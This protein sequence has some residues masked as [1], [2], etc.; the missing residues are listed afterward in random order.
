MTV[1]KNIG[2]VST[3]PNWKSINWAKVQEEVMKLQVRIA[4]ATK[5]RRWNKVKALQWLLTHSFSAKC[6]AVKRVTTNRGKKTPGVDGVILKK[7]VEKY[8]MVRSMSRR[9]YQPQ[10]LRRI[11]IPKSGGGNKKR[12]LGIPTMLDRAQQALHA[13]ALSPVAETTADQNSYGFRPERSTADAIQRIHATTSRKYDPQ[14]V[15]EGDIKGCFDNISHDW[16]LRNVVMDRVVLQKWLKAGFLE[17][18]TLFPTDK[19]T[20]QGGIISPCLANIVLDG[21]EKALGQIF[22]RQRDADGRRSRHMR[23]LTKLNGVR[24]CRYADDFVI[25]GSSRELLENEVKP[26]IEVFLKERGLELSDEKTKITHTTEGYDFLGQ[27]VRRHILRSGGSVLLIRPSKKNIHAFLTTIRTTIKKM[28]TSKQEDL[29]QKLNPM[30]R[31]WGNYHRHVAS[32]DVYNKVDHEIWTALW[33][34]AKRRH[35]NKGLKWI[36]RRY[37]RTIKGV[38]WVF[39]CKMLD[40]TGNQQLLTLA[41]TSAIRIIRHAHIKLSANPFDPEWDAYFEQRQSI[42]M[43]HSYEGRGTLISLWRKQEG[44]CPQCGEQLPASGQTGIIQYKKSRSK[45]GDPTLSNLILLH[46]KCHAEGHKMSS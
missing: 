19:G 23:R 42:K 28:A 12:P 17:K 36:N 5:Q 11:Y 18:A 16:L 29:I 30:I 34:W 37:F 27:H 32:K 26:V 44:L 8:Q 15:L 3:P 6:L 33:R 20:P 13:L 10:P 40:E 46:P 2:A 14:W 41:T 39:S 22:G 31:G 43:R 35:P 4:K 7:D 45:G 38:R 1:L 21:M 25:S 9:N 24:I